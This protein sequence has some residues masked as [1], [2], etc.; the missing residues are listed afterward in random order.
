MIWTEHHI[1]KLVRQFISGG[2]PSRKR[3]EY[4]NGEIPW[5]TGA[6]FLDGEV[7]YWVT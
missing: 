5:I 4:W 2:T 3:Q 6:D 7:I 1:S